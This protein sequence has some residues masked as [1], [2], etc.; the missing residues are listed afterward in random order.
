MAKR[1]LTVDDSKTI[2]LI[3]TRAFKSFDIDI[4]EAADGVEGLAVAA[5]EKPDIIILDYTI[6]F[7]ITIDRIFFLH[8]FCNG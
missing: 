1:I 2:R 3:V 8:N 7:T 6:K 4:F 5:R